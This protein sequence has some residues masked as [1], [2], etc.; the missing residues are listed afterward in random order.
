MLVQRKFNTRQWL[1][2]VVQG[3]FN[4]YA[5]PGN[6]KKPGGVSGI[7]CLGCGGIHSAAAARSAGYRGVNL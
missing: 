6:L 1:P 7:G 2:S 5:V 4:Y 3:Y